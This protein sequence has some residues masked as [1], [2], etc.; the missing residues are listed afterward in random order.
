MITRP[1]FL[2]SKS[3]DRERSASLP[4]RSGKPDQMSEVAN[5]LFSQVA[6]EKAGGEGLIHSERRD[7][8]GDAG[9]AV[10]SRAPTLESLHDELREVPPSSSTSCDDRRD[11]SGPVDVDD[12]RFRD[13]SGFCDLAAQSLSVAKKVM[14]TS[15]A[16]GGKLLRMTSGGSA[17][18]RSVGASVNRNVEFQVNALEGDFI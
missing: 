8:D 6:L 7:C 11:G 18:R 4:V 13:D 5:D 1:S 3:G 9:R 14:R 2:R 15:G 16:S 12:P 10:S 17:R